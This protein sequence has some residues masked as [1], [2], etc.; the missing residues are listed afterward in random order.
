MIIC[1][2]HSV[3]KTT[4]LQALKTQL[5]TINQNLLTKFEFTEISSDPTQQDIDCRFLTTETAGDAYKYL[6]YVADCSQANSHHEIV[7]IHTKLK[8]LSG[9]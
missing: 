3:G 6:I 4:I 7:P 9:I 1:G 8:G 2:T 5:A